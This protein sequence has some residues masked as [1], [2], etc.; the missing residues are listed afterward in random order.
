MHHPS[1]LLNL[2]RG[3]A[4]TLLLATFCAQLGCVSSAPSDYAERSSLVVV[5]V[6]GEVQMSWMSQPGRSYTILYSDSAEAAPEQ[7]KPL[8]GYTEIPGN[9]EN[10]TARDRHPARVE[11]KYRLR[12]TVK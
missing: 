12:S 4:G 5:E 3:L 11:R 1:S 2:S 7:W 6:E 9:G 8:P 10:M